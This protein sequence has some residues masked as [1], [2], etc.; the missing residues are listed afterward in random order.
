MRVIVHLGTERGELVGITSGY[1]PRNRSPL[2]WIMGSRSSAFQTSDAE[3]PAHG[4]VLPEPFTHAAP[5]AAHG[6]EV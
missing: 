1:G 3:R 4:V 2:K 5:A 6:A